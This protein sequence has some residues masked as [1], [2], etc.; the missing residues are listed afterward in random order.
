MPGV[1]YG[2]VHPQLITFHLV[3]F[4]AGIGVLPRADHCPSNVSFLVEVPPSHFPWKE[5]SKGCGMRGNQTRVV[6]TQT[7]VTVLLQEIVLGLLLRAILT[8]D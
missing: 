1:R 5:Q 3:E 6:T 7:R 8:T 2:S 4:V